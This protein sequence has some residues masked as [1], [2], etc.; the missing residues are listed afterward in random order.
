MKGIMALA[1]LVATAVVCAGCGDSSSSSS[2]SSSSGSA[3][4]DKSPYTIGSLVTE[5]GTFASSDGPGA[6]GIKAWAQY[7]NAHGGI[8]GHPV[9]LD[10]KDDKNNPSV[11][12][13]AIKQWAAN[14]DVV[15]VVGS[16]S[17]VE[18]SWA[19][20]A[21]K[22]GLPVVGDFPFTPVSFTKK[23]VFP[24]ATTF[25]SVLYGEVYSS[26]KLAKADNVAFF[27]CAEEPAC[28]LS[29]PVVK[30]EAAALGGSLVNAQGIPATAPNYDAQC[31]AAK[32]AGADAVILA[33]GAGTIMS[34]AQSCESVGYH[35]AYV[36][37]TTSV[38]PQMGTV[39]ALK[40]SS[41]GVVGTF[42]WVA[43]K[44]PGQ[45]AFQEG[46]K[47]VN[48]PADKMGAAVSLGW[49]G[50]ALFE[51]AAKTVSGDLTRE[52]LS[53][54]LWSLP[55]GTTLDGLAPPLTYKRD[56]PSPEQKCFFVMKMSNGKW[57]APYG[58]TKTFCQP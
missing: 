52:S 7:V 35:P 55:K 32:K 41:Y 54:A 53:D 11:A 38:T 33:L 14:K 36:F 15:A 28:A 24:Q 47:A 58:P 22:V 50:G 19:P 5:T 37:Q 9:K 12:V 39:A 10:L 6:Y 56:A 44:T 20:V 57:S 23:Y 29:T 46:V 8:N 25:P 48:V 1:A 26:V 4:A 45:K 31:T 21:S 49:T 2:T 3:S 42:P 43:H 18:Q 27:Y 16:V 30:K 51:A 17:G 40:D 34:L 13:S